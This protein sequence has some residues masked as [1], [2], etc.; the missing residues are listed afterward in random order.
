VQASVLGGGEGSASN[1]VL[2]DVTP[3]TLGVE[4]VGGVMNV[5]LPRNSLVPTKKSQMFT[6]VEDNQDK[7]LF[8]VYEGER[9]MT[10]DN[11]ILGS[12]ELTGIRP[13][14][15]GDAQIEVTFEVDVNGILHVT[16]EDLDTRKKESIT[17]TKEKD[18]LKPEDIAR[19]LR[20][21]EL[22]AEEDKI[23]RAQVEARN[24][25]ELYSQL[26]RVASLD[27][28]S[29]WDLPKNSQEKS[30][31]LQV[32]KQVEEYLQKSSKNLS[33]RESEAL[34]AQLKRVAGPLMK[35]TRYDQRYEDIS[36]NRD[37]GEDKG[38]EFSEEEDIGRSE[39]EGQEEE[40][41]GGNDG[42]FHEEL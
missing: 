41:I 31:I 10:R 34:L 25:L 19:M 24:S 5:V 8:E 13:A 14:P 1:I 17:I 3:L 18:R 30:E 21:A 27:P 7:I 2:L 32:R 38:E 12:F 9:T 36:N 16:A 28:K 4:T 39:G 35:R 33:Q 23:V 6:T 29:G 37:G 26:V 20:E 11:H 42:Q 15:N 40:D 22:N